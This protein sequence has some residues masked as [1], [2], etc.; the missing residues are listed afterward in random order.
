MVKFKY[1]YIGII[2][3][4][5]IQLISTSTEDFCFSNPLIFSSIS[6]LCRWFYENG[7]SKTQNG[8]Y[9]NIQNS[10]IDQRI[11][12][13]K[14]YVKYYNINDKGY[15]NCLDI[16]ND[17]SETKNK[18]YNFKKLILSNILEKSYF[19]NN[20]IFKTIKINN[21]FL[22]YSYITI[23]SKNIAGYRNYGKDYKKIK[24]ETHEE[25]IILSIIGSYFD[26]SGDPLFDF[27]SKE[28]KEICINKNIMKSSK[29]IGILLDNYCLFGENEENN[30]QN[31]DKFHKFEG[32]INF[33]IK[34]NNVTTIKNFCISVDTNNTQWNDIL[35]EL[36]QWIYSL[37]EKP[38]VIIGDYET[39][40]LLKSILRISKYNNTYDTIFDEIQLIINK[41]K[42]NFI[43]N[44]YRKLIAINFGDIFWVSPKDD[45]VDIYFSYD[46]E[47]NID[48]F[49]IDT[50]GSLSIGN[51]NNINIL[52]VKVIL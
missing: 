40:S 3:M 9:S 31:D 32:L 2:Y 12:Y 36:D 38:D 18:N 15:K 22:T 6:S 27:Y 21:P 20:I 16:I 50:C 13:N 24:Q 42:K 26:K 48:N 28:E 23:K 1:I 29:D 34:N 49:S 25:H 7:Y 44:E 33:A 47:G 11:I 4:K 52:K 14:F 5:P 10:L 37:E 35:I 19:F 30:V 51:I 8:A 17:L 39:I 46:R 43:D 45:L 41:N